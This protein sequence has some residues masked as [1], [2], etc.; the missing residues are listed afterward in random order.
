MASLLSC[1]AAF[2]FWPEAA[3]SSFEFDVAYRRDKIEWEIDA[4]TTVPVDGVDAPVKL[5]SKLEWRDLDIWQVGLRGKY[6]TCD[7]LYLRG[8]ADYGWI[9]HGKVSDRDYITADSYYSDCDCDSYSDYSNYYS[10]YDYYSNFCC[11]DYSSYS[12]DS[13]NSGVEFASSCGRSKKGHVYDASLALGY[14]F[15]WC[16]DSVGLAPVV[17][18][19]WHGQHLNIREGYDYYN[20]DTNCGCDSVSGLNSHYHTRWNGPFLG[21]DFDYR[22]GCEWTL[23]ASYEYHWAH[24]HAKADWNLRSDLVDGFN[25]RSHNAHGQIATL[26]LKWDFCECWTL[27]LTGQWQW[28]QARHGKD[29]ALVADVCAGDLDVECFLTTPLRQVKWQSASISLDIGMV[30]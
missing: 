22:F 21:L 18:Y 13:C 10:C 26:G 19:S 30:F 4:H 5:A 15:K 2:A 6:V 9:T 12:Y 25:H 27:G 23:F 14:L 8:Y 20:Q 24:Y 16:D 7:N 3:D 28:F 29:R 17:G 11:N 1:S